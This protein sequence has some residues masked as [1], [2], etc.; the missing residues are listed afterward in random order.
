MKLKD[1]KFADYLSVFKLI[2]AKLIT[3]FWGKYKGCWVICE[4]PLEA[5]D[6]GYHFFKYVTKAHPEIKVVY[7]L[8]RNS[9]DYKKVA[10]C[11]EVIEYGSMKHWILYLLAE[12]NISSQKSGKPNWALCAFL[13]LLGLIDSKLVFLQHGVTINDVEWLHADLCQL[14][15][16]VTSTIPE[17]EFIKNTFGYEDNKIILTGLPR[18]DNLH[19]FKTDKKLILIMP[20]WRARF[21]MASK[22]GNSDNDF[23]HSAYKK[24]WEELLNDERLKELMRLQNIKVMFFLHR[25]MQPFVDS[26]EVNNT[27]IEM[28]KWEQYDIQEVLKKAALMITD[29]SSVFFDMVYMKKPV[30]FYQFDYE[31]F[32]K[33]DYKD[34]YFDYK[35]NVFS[36]WCRTSDDV[37]N[38]LLKHISDEFMLSTEFLNGHEKIFQYYDTNNSSRIAHILQ[39][40]HDDCLSRNTQKEII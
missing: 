40:N 6:N 25:D 9:P 7:A 1:V 33:R 16:F 4:T 37:M 10:R 28:V 20:T 18:F 32:R 39:N 27:D 17:Y 29:F 35:N 8:K 21:T 2:I 15:Y 38:A 31:E 30:I 23:I 19:D 12:Y 22:K 3:P 14:K 24:K 36:D 34:G 26:F 13:E 5:R 11:G